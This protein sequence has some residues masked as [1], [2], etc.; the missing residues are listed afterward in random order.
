MHQGEL[1][2]KLF[3]RRVLKC[4]AATTTA[5]N[6][7]GLSRYSNASPDPLKSRWRAAALPTCGLVFMFF[8]L[9]CRQCLQIGCSWSPNGC[10]WANAGERNVNTQ[11]SL[12]RLDESD[13]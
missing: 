2:N 7:T 9:R 4:I 12:N 11:F 6:E 8:I 10:T 13:L 1:S 3:N 5:G